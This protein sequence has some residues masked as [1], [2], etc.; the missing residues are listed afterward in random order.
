ME[1]SLKA[2]LAILRA[3]YST[4]MKALNQIATMPRKTREQRYA[5]DCVKFLDSMK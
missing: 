5:S 3:R 1:N 4:A 2:E